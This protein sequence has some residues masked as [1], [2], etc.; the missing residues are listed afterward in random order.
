M[1]TTDQIHVINLVTEKS[2]PFDKEVDMLFVDFKGAYDSVNREE[3]LS[4]MLTKMGV[5]GIFVR[6]VKNWVPGCKC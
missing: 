1:I 2:Q 3:T 6:I 4:A 5:P